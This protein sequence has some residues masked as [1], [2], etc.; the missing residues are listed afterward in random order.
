MENKRDIFSLGKKTLP[1]LVQEAGHRSARAQVPVS[2]A[3]Q[4]QLKKN[5]RLM[6][7]F[8]KG[9]TAGQRERQQEDRG[10]K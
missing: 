10:K 4:E 3:M 6:E 5:L 8:M 1:E 9:A 2:K 7:R